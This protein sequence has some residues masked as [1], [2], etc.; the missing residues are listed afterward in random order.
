MSHIRH[1]NRGASTK[2]TAA[3]AVVASIL[4]VVG[5]GNAGATI[6]DT[7]AEPSAPSVDADEYQPIVVADAYHGI[8]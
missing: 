6:H 1:H 4:V 2:A 5:A 7:P 8:G 3:L